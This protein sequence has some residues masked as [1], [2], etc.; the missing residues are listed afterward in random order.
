M[1]LNL[2]LFITCSLI[3]GPFMVVF[4]QVPVWVQS[5]WLWDQAQWIAFRIGLV[6]I[7]WPWA[8]VTLI[9]WARRF[10]QWLAEEISS[11]P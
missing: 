5:H 2:Y 11:V 8:I 1:K 6:I 10:W 9:L 3:L 7:W 4:G